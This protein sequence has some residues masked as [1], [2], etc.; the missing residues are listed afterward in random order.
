M[1]FHHTTTFHPTP[2]RS[3]QLGG[4]AGG[5]ALRT[6]SCGKDL[7]GAFCQA[8][9]QGS[10]VPSTSDGTADSY[11]RA[12]RYA[13][14][15]AA[16]PSDSVQSQP[17]H[18]SR[19]G[20]GPVEPESVQSQPG[21]SAR[22]KVA[23]GVKTAATSTDTVE[24]ARQSRQGDGPVDSDSV[25]SQPARQSRQSDGPVEPEAYSHKL[26]IRLDKATS[27]SP[28]VGLDKVIPSTSQIELNPGF[29]V[30]GLATACQP[31]KP[32]SRPCLHAACADCEEELYEVAAEGATADAKDIVADVRQISDS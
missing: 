14:Y 21:H 1:A 28:G 6:G 13:R 30:L 32:T 25:Q 18:Q 2:V 19:Q 3:R 26:A 20:D 22:L 17:T 9:C 10:S 16:T 23:A 12:A 27:E 29:D 11:N 31:S 5:S 7:L 24:P 15:A 8:P 4:G